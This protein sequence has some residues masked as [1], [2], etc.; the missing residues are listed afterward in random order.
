MPRATLQALVGAR[1][2]SSSEIGEHWAFPPPA[3]R[4]W[5]PPARR[6]GA[7][8]TNAP[9]TCRRRARP[10][11][12]PDAAHLPAP[13]STPGQR[14]PLAAGRIAQTRAWLH[15][16]E[17]RVQRL[18]RR[19]R[20]VRGAASPA[21]CAA[22]QPAARARHVPRSRHGEDTVRQLFRRVARGGELY[23]GGA[24]PLF[25][26]RRGGRTGRHR[27]RLNAEHGAARAADLRDHHRAGRTQGGHPHPRILRPHRLH[28]PRA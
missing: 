17:H 24:R 2:L 25:H 10:P 26:R 27:R 20:P 21:R 3:G 23:P 22:L 16:P 7:P 8:N 11:A 4:R 13:P 14:E 15:L 5:K 19:P 1:R 9:R 28:S 6:P 12:P 18:G